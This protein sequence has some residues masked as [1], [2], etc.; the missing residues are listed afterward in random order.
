MADL[1]GRVVAFLEARRATE[2][3]S[4]I[5]RH[6]GVPYSAPCLREVHDPATPD[7]AGAVER[8]CDPAVAAAIFLTGVG[9]ATIFEAARL[10]GR[11]QELLAALDRK[12]VAARGPKPSAVL[13]KAGVRID[14]VSP[15]PHTSDDLLA[16]LAAWDLRD[17]DVAVQLY[18]GPP[19]PLCAA[20]AERGARIVTLTPYTWARPEQVV[21]VLDLIRALAL[22]QVQAL[23][24]TNTAQVA[25]LFTIAREH[26]E[27]PTLRR[28]LRDVPVAAQGP[29]CA[30]AFERE[31]VPVAILPEHGHMGGLVLAIAGYF[32][33]HAGRAHRAAPVAVV[34]GG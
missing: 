10:R 25:N 21:P 24:A 6:G 34:A 11:E 13:R 18:G 4:L 16:A 20:L 3:A 23:A 2:L 27:E 12:R 19:P 15:A 9:T 22:G 32:A 26:G 1:Q 28:A 30:G 14:L 8:L 5:Q 17:R 29:V 33:D 31:G 7:L